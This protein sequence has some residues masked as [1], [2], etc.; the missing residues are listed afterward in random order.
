MIGR[1]KALGVLYTTVKIV[2]LSRA[3]GRRRVA[4]KS[5]EVSRPGGGGEGPSPTFG[6]G[7][8]EPR[9]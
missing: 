7:R 1:L 6:R 3:S 9:T 8:A 5:G 2:W 4:V